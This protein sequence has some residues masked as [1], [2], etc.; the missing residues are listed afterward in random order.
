MQFTK[1]DTK[2]AKNLLSMMTSL[3]VM[4]AMKTKYDNEFE[5]DNDDGILKTDCYNLDVLLSRVIS[6]C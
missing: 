2:S 5:S 4:T 3:K 6:L 1:I